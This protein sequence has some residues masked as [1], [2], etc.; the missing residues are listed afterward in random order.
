M[1]GQPSGRLR[2]EPGA[3]SSRMSRQA[4][5]DTKPELQLRSEL[6][7][8]GLRYFVHR[9]PLPDLRREADVVF[10][11]L[12]VAVFV[13]GCFWHG[14]DQHRTSPMRNAEFWNQKID[15][16]RRRDLETDVHLAALGWT[17]VRVWEHERT[18]E[19]ADRVEEVVR[20]AR[21]GLD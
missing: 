5:R 19:A 9:R 20:Q 7:R 17:A 16:N 1:G 21:A 2:A 12:R 8:R 11:R 13:N 18:E 4:S 3:A 14:C 6:H 10:P 15:G